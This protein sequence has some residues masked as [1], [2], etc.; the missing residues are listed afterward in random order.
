MGSG[1]SKDAN[2]GDGE[3]SKVYLLPT[4]NGSSSPLAQGKTNSPVGGKSAGSNGSVTNASTPG[5]TGTWE[6]DQGSIADDES[7]IVASGGAAAAVVS[8]VPPAMPPKRAGRNSSEALVDEEYD[9]GPQEVSSYNAV[10]GHHQE[11][12]LNG[13]LFNA[14]NT[15]SGAATMS[16]TGLTPFQPQK[17]FPRLRL[18]AGF[19][20]RLLS[21]ADTGM[22]R[23][24]GAGQHSTAELFSEHIQYAQPIDFRVR[25]CGGQPGPIR[26]LSCNA[27][28]SQFAAAVVGNKTCFIV[29]A[30]TGRTTATIKGHL[31]PVL[32]CSQSRDSKFLVTTSADCTVLLWDMNNGKRLR[33][34]PVNFQANVCAVSDDSEVVAT[35]STDDVVYLWDAKTCD[36]LFY[37][38]RHTSPIFSIAFSRQGGLFAS[39]GT[40]GELFVWMH[41]TGDVR[42]TFTKHR[43]SILAVSFSHDGRRLVSVDRECLR[44]WD[45]F[46]GY[47][48]FTR[49]SRGIV[50]VGPEG[51]D[52]K[53]GMSHVSST[54]LMANGYDGSS[55]SSDPAAT[56]RYL[57]CAFIAGNLVAATLSTRQ[58][59]VIEPNTGKELLSIQTKGVVTAMCSSYNGDTLIVGDMHGNQYQVKLLF[60]LQDT[61]VFNLG[62]RPATKEKKGAAMD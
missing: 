17:L 53:G 35:T 27:D 32:N 58:L 44:M 16:T 6:S 7:A 28:G 11:I 60:S 3:G 12:S 43:T 59:L 40:N 4:I 62:A 26:S 36:Q 45:M 9:D 10:A 23:V 51:S 25:T 55:G 21:L 5:G 39:G 34:I 19:D 13:Y 8:T 24:E 14:P 37:F 50:S 18:N 22:S 1:G 33:E 29:D 46:T 31:D 38:Q 52:E 49:D 54:S 42:Y 61:R 47:C 57:S 56:V 48:V 41:H 30:A 15:T 20:A 2:G